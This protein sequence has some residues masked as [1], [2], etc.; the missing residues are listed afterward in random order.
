[1]N[2]LLDKIPAE[3]R[4][5]VNS[6]LT[7]IPVKLGALARALGVEVTAATLSPGI[8]GEIRR[9]ANGDGEGVYQIRIN[10]H[11]KKERQRFTLAHEIAHFLLHRDKIGDGLYD[12]V[13]YRSKLSN[14]LEYEANRLAA[15]IVMPAAAV[16]DISKDAQYI[17][18]EK[19]EEISNLFGVSKEAMTIRLGIT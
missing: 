10:R 4:E 11:E 16:K 1:M 14:H 17:D 5:I 9:I 15:E 3:Q 8:S 12:D 19:V 2:R 13:L 18:D 6:H 7:D